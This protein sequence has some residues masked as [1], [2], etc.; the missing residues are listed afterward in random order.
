[1][2]SGVGCIEPQQGFTKLG[3]ACARPQPDG[4]ELAG[5]GWIGDLPLQAAIDVEPTTLAGQINA[6]DALP[7]LDIDK[8][9]AHF[10]GPAGHGALIHRAALPTYLVDTGIDQGITGDVALVGELQRER[11]LENLLGLLTEQP[12]GVDGEAEPGELTRAQQARLGHVGPPV[13]RGLPASAEQ[14]QTDQTSLPGMHSTLSQ[15]EANL[16]R[17]E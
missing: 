7:R 15:A 17:L 5:E 14:Q 8:G 1:N 6:G 10:F 4:K 3:A 9:L 13:G 12:C 16:G 11:L 2:T